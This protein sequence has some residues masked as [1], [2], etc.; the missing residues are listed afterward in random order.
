MASSCPSYNFSPLRN[1]SRAADLL[2]S[3]GVGVARLIGS[4]TPKYPEAAILY[5]PGEVGLGGTPAGSAGRLG[6]DYQQAI[7]EPVK[8]ERLRTRQSYEATRRA[9]A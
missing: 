7:A 4:E 1:S 3:T 6:T 8:S 5:R 9:A 2:T